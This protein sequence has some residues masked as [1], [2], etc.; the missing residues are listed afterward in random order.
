MW[1][2]VYLY[3]CQFRIHMARNPARSW[4]IILQQAWA[5][6]LKDRHRLT[7]YNKSDRKSKRET[8]WRFNRGK[9]SYGSSCK[10]E[11]KRG[12]C[13]K[14]G[15]GTFNCRRLQDKGDRNNNGSQSNNNNGNRRDGNNRP[16]NAMT[17]K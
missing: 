5:M 3:D 11:H 13:G 7:D 17:L 10:F 6:Y 8:C 1:E 2:N 15:H 4:A 12:T 16:S 9:C 14:F